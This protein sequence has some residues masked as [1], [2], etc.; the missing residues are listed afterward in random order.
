MGE[1]TVAIYRVCTFRRPVCLVASGCEGLVVHVVCST[2]CVISFVQVDPPSLKH[3]LYRMSHVVLLC[4]SFRYHISDSFSQ[5]QSPTVCVA[6]GWFGPCHVA[7]A[8][9]TVLYSTALP[10]RYSKYSSGGTWN[11]AEVAESKSRDCTRRAYCEV[12]TIPNRG[13]KSKHRVHSR[14]ERQPW[15]P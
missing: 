12:K 7:L 3:R 10:L 6:T 15:R 13:G 11:K 5:P 1:G 14:S 9:V 8:A 2:N 4:S